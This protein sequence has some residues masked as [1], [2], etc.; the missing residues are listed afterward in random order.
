MEQNKD[1]RRTTRTNTQGH[2]LM[3]RFT[4]HTRRLLRDKPKYGSFTVKCRGSL[5]DPTRP[6]SLARTCSIMV[7][8]NNPFQ[9]IKPV[10]NHEPLPRKKPGSIAVSHTIVDQTESVPTVTSKF[11]LSSLGLSYRVAYLCKKLYYSLE[12]FTS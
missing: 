9:G 5:A 6:C 1:S 11:T 2:E 4:S 3:R 12:A 8:Q 7:P 10:Q